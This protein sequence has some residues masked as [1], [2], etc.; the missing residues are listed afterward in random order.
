MGLRD[1]DITG[2]SPI[3][4]TGG[5]R[6]LVVTSASLVVTSALL[7]VTSALLVVTRSY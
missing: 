4:P 7:V 6:K 3:I 1:G 2:G 5:G